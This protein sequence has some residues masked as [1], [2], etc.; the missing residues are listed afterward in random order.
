MGRVRLTEGNPKTPKDTPRRKVEE[1]LG[2]EGGASPR[3]S[4]YWKALRVCPRESALR[5]IAK[6]V[7]MG[8]SQ[9]ALDVGLLFHHALEN[10]YLVLQ[11]SQARAER[12]RPLKKRKLG[13]EQQEWCWSGMAEA[14]RAAWLSIKQFSAEEGYEEIYAEVERLV[15]SYLEFYRRKDLWRVVSV[16]ETLQYA[17]AGMAYSARLDLIVEDLSAGGLYVIEHKTA[18]SASADVLEGYQM[19]MQIL[20][21]VWLL[22]ACVDFTSLPTLKGVRVNITTK[23]KTPQHHRV[24]VLPSNLHLKSFED[25]QRNLFAVAAYYAKL[26]WP[27]HLGN[28]TGAARYF[29]RCGFFDVCH[30]HPAD[31]VEEL[32]D[33]PPF[34]YKDTSDD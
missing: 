6:L 15:G 16:E 21:Q 14:E 12:E 13:L 29:Q 26:G 7:P 24:E 8:T 5:N 25:E 18:R 30:G 31:T 3:G 9:T 22:G 20:G 23:H 4:S 34:G 17:D 27:K 33:N 28:C 2:V 32:R 10:Y 11:A 1:V 19:D